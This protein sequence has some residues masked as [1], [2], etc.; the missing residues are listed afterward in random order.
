MKSSRILKI[1]SIL[2][3]LC[4]LGDLVYLGYAFFSPFQIPAY[5]NLVAQNLGAFFSVYGPLVLIAI[6]KLLAGFF[7]FRYAD[8]PRKASR[9]LWWGITAL[10]ASAWGLR[11]SF[12]S[13]APSLAV[14]C[15]GLVV[16]IFYMGAAAW[17]DW[18]KEEG[19]QRTAGILMLCWSVIDILFPYGLLRM[20]LANYSFLAQNYSLIPNYSEE[21]FAEITAGVHEVFLQTSLLC[22]VYFLAQLLTGIFAIRSVKAPKKA[23]VCIVLSVVTAGLNATRLLLDRSEDMTGLLL[24]LFAVSLA[25][26]LL[27][28]LSSVILMKANRRQTPEVSEE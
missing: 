3:A 1:I 7:G 19:L 9:C 21:Y 17:N 16:S 12:S 18:E 14:L 4:G 2:L 11:L 26:S 13:S 10:A 25:I 24:T 5:A 15:A 22:L 23:T 8:E 27:C 20:T 6:L 28:I